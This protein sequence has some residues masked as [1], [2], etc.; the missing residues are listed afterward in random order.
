M[1]LMIESL[2][3]NRDLQLSVK[4]L[5]SSYFETFQY[6]RIL[7]LLLKSPI[8]LYLSDGCAFGIK[9]LNLFFIKSGFLWAFLLELGLRTFISA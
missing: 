6:G 1:S 3:Y 2:C 8:Y 7:Y 5:E 9:V 4:K